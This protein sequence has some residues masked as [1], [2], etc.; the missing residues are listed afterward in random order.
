MGIQNAEYNAICTELF[1]DQDVT[2]HDA[3]FLRAIAEV[4]AARPDHYMQADL[5]LLAHGGNHA[6]AGRDTAFI[7]ACTQFN[8]V[9]ATTL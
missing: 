6:C 7:K 3:D 9:S 8:T 5:N 1:C 4:S 2:L